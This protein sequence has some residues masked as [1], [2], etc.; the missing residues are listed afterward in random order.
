M[1]VSVIS[2]HAGFT[3]PSSISGLANTV[4]FIPPHHTTSGEIFPR[5]WARTGFARTVDWIAVE[6]FR[7]CLAVFTSGVIATILKNQNTKCMNLYGHTISDCILS[8]QAHS[9]FW[10]TFLTSS[11]AITAHRFADVVINRFRLFVGQFRLEPIVS[12]TRI[13]TGET[14][15]FGR[16]ITSLDAVSMIIF[17]SYYINSRIHGNVC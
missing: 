5:L 9:R 11:V 14:A 1:R 7:T 17:R 6:T 15:V 10:L 3:Q 2:F 13:L 16:T 8:H 12:L 4:H